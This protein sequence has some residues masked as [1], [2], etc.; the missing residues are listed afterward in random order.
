VDISKVFPLEVSADYDGVRLDLFLSKSF[1]EVSRSR[2]GRLIAKGAISINGK[3]AE[4]SKKI[5]AGQLI[6]A[7][8]DFEDFSEGFEASLVE[9]V[10]FKGEEPEVIF[11]DSDIL[12]LNKPQGLAVHPGSGLA[13]EETLVAWLIQ[14]KKL[15]DPK[16]K[17]FLKWGEDILEEGR[18]GIVHRLDKGTSGAIVIA[19]NPKAHGLLSKQFESRE[20]GREYLAVV[21]GSVKR[22]LKTRP[23]R[24][25]SL[26]RKIPCPVALKIEEEG[27]FSIATF[28]ERDPMDRTRFRVSG[29]EGKRGVTHFNEVASSG[30]YSLLRLKLD[31]GRTHQIRIHLSFLGYPIVGDDVYGGMP[32]RRMMLHAQKLRLTHPSTSEKLEFSAVIPAMDRAW[33]VGEELWKESKSH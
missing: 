11:E 1:P 29:G 4:A 14:N 31:T 22:L 16:S 8:E 20:A 23:P 10:R 32:F 12:L 30:T 3:A 5:K 7:S 2:W 28:F 26:L 25:E 13:I 15:A 27:K 18:P 17:E 9:E 33:L 24:L 19:K 6:D 21:E